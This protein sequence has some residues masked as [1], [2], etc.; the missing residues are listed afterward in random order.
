MNDYIEKRACRR[1]NFIASITCTYFNADRFYSAKTTNHSKEGLLFE[2][3]F[4]LIPGASVY[5]RVEDLSLDASGSKGSRRSR[6]PS[7]SLAQV[8]WCREIYDPGG[9]YYKVGLKYYTP[10]I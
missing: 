3:N 5:I 10:A 1:N 9:N 2:S 7:L 6:L 4:P 8:R